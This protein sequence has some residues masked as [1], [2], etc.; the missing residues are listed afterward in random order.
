MSV[1][2]GAEVTESITHIGGSDYY[3]MGWVV[4]SRTWA[5]GR[6]LTHDGTNTGNYSVTWI[7]P[8]RGFAILGLSNSYDAGASARVS[9]A[10][11]ALMGR[12][13]QYYDTAD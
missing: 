7:A 5:N 9:S 3:G 1:Q 6:T 2:A 13:I 4:T 12:L 11:E 8:T 10:V